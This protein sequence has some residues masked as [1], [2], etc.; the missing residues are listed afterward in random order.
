M[1]QI[2]KNLIGVMAICVVML[3]GTATAK[4]DVEGYDYEVENGEVCITGY[5]GEE[6]A[7]VIPSEIEGYPVTSIGEYAFY[8]CLDITSVEIPATV[9]TIGSNAFATCWDM[10]DIVIP[11]SVTEIGEGAFYYCMSLKSVTIPASVTKL[12]DN[13][14]TMCTE[15]E[16]VNL[17]DTLT[18]IGVSAF[19]YCSALSE[20]VIPSG[21]TSIGADAFVNCAG[22]TAV[23]IPAS[24]TEIGT[25]AF[26]YSK[27]PSGTYTKNEIEI[28]GNNSS[29]A[30]TYAVENGFTFVSNGGPAKPV[31]VTGVR[32]VYKDGKI[33]LTWDDCGAVYYKVSRSDG[34]SGYQNL[35]Y[36]ATAE[37]WVDENLVPAQLYFYRITGY[38]KDA[39]GGLISGDISEA[40]AAVATDSEPEKVV[41]VTA[42]VRNGAVTLNWDAADGARYYKISRASGAT[43]QYYT[44]KYNIENTTYTD[45]SVF[46]GL[47]RY[48]VVGYYKDV[49]GSW[50]YGELCDTLYV[51]V[52]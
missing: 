25:H 18:S 52:K 30:E 20:I 8:A 19:E 24:V 15:L 10:T 49:D 21:V 45:T 50:V 34:R 16:T 3:L 9:K 43:G 32:A 6:T 40:A 13:A 42:S 41:N 47:Y 11:P 7:V 38:F 12:P 23:E 48:K 17:P 5:Y 1:K 35:T 26:G 28:T 39:N 4:A 33:Q 51:T 27:N 2:F 46:N 29:A 14:F 37:G 22:L 44:M 31:M 36:S